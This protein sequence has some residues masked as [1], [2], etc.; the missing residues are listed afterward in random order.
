MSGSNP[1]LPDTPQSLMRRCDGP[2]LLF[3]AA[4]LLT[5]CLTGGLLYLALGTWWAVPATVLHGVVIVH[6]FA[7]FHETAHGTAF[8]SPRL[9]EAVGF[10]TGLVLLLPALQFRHEHRAHH[11]YTQDPARDPQRIPMAERLGGYLFYAT[12]IPYFYNAIATLIRHALGRF[13]AMERQFLP[14]GVRPRVQ[15]QAWLM[16]GIY[17][18][19][20]GVSLAAQ[21]WAAAVYWLLPRIAGEPLMRLI[22]MSEHGA[23]PL[24]D[25]IWRNTRT[26]LTWPPIR[27]L[28][29]N[30]AYHAEHHARAAVPFH[31]LPELHRRIG[32]RFEVVERGYWRAQRT[33]IRNGLRNS[34][35]G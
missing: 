6:L 11:Q 23:C 35:L 15:R 3:L 30:M 12:A 22:R 21:S 31:A 17:A 26:V 24:S 18:V 7:P 13:S 20:L 19:V 8:R 1:G 33:L 14:A 27:W 32:E 28:A 25:D 2:G 16:W 4:H 5:L 10:L 34:T 9:N 29:W